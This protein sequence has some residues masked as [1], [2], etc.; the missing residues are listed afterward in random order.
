MEIT[1]T[2][3]DF[4]LMQQA[5]EGYK[6]V[7]NNIQAII[8]VYQAILSALRV[9]QVFTG[10]AATSMIETIQTM[11]KA[12]DDAKANLDQLVATL[13]QKLENYQAADAQ[14]QQIASGAQQAVWQTV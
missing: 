2:I 4:G 3:V 5:I 8:D 1:V 10:G 6:K 9:A 12:M 14:A 7:S 11:V 13:S